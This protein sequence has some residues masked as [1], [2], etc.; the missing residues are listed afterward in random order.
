MKS[1]LVT[2]GAGFI[3]SH[4]VDR[5]L[6]QDAKVICLDNFNEF[7]DPRLKENNISKAMAHPGFTLVK[8]DILDSNLL[9]KVFSENEIEVV[10]HLAA[11]AGVRP[12]LISPARYVEVDV[13][14]TVNLLEKCKESRAKFVFGSSSSVYGVNEKVPFSED[15]AT[16]LQVSPYAAAKKAAEIYCKTYNRLYGIPV[17]ILRFFTVY[18]PRQRPDMAIRK[19]TALMSEGKPIPMYGDGNSERDYT[20]IDDAVDG[21]ISA[22]EKNYDFE[23]FNIG[24]SKTIRLTD[25]IELIGRKLGVKPII[26]ELLEQPGDV[27]ITYADISKA[28]RMLDYNPKTSIEDGIE[29]FI[30]WFKFNSNS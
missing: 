3:G 24:N 18:G 22:I 11:L 6:K 14:G 1:I 28:Q 20:Y 19:F 26:E 12:S 30:E 2:G 21:V 17:T 5:L 8:G 13:E 29:R 4:I 25:L 9:A 10:V 27:P 23:V 16:E 15:D 7:Y